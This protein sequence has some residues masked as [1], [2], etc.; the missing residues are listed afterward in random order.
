[1]AAIRGSHTKP[2]LL[3]RK[4]LHAAGFRFR[5]HVRDLPGKPDLVF[6]KYSA[7]IFVNGCFWHHHD[8]HLFKWPATREAFWREKIGRN[9]EN[10]RKASERLREAGWRVATVWECAL[11]GRT[12]LAPAMV[13]ERLGT[14]LRSDN[15]TLSLRGE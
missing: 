5:L 3:I 9:V 4:L 10:D 1:M 6:P 2:E 15:P 13:G 11:K 7:V 12:R 14:W 8:C